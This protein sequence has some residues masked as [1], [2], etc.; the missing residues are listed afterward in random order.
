MATWISGAEDMLEDIRRIDE[1]NRAVI[2]PTAVGSIRRLAQRNWSA[3]SIAKS[4]RLEEAQVSE[5]IA[6]MDERG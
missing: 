3:S 5:V 1:E 4:L 2:T 6:T